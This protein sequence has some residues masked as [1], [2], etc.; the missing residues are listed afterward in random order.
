MYGVE[1]GGSL[2]SSLVEGWISSREC[3][4]LVQK[5]TWWGL[6]SEQVTDPVPVQPLGEDETA[7]KRDVLEKPLR[8]STRNWRLNISDGS[9]IF[10]GGVPH[11]Q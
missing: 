6:T 5:M 1:D 8:R 11:E 3:H 9:T 10:K 7:N 2:S 4:R